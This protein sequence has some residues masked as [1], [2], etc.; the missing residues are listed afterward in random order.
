MLYKL[1]NR[2][3]SLTGEDPLMD[4]HVSFIGPQV[5]PFKIKRQLYD[6]EKVLTYIIIY[7]CPISMQQKDLYT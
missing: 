2:L 3:I 5:S 7:N 1:Q 6:G 4:K